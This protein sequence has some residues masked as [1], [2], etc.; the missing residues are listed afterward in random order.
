MQKVYRLR[1]GFQFNYIYRKGK[2][3]AGKE[4]VLT[5]AKNRNSKLLVGVSC[6]KKIGKANV[7]NKVKRQF[8]EA[9]RLLI[10]QI[11]NKYNYILV[12]RADAVDASYQ[13]IEKTL[14]YLLAKSGKLKNDNDKK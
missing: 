13:N 8:K 5:C 1:K 3:V 6:S 7:R 9:F 11:D 2:S 4:M 12:A 10:P 14:K